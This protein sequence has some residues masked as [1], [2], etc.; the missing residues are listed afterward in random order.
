MALV[1]NGELVTSSFVDASGA[2][3]IPP[4]GPV[5]VSLAQWKAQREELLAARH[6]ARYSPA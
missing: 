1:K 5:I 2:E 4:T 6:A 3:A